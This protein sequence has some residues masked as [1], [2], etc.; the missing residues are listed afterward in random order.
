[1]FERWL[2]RDKI[3]AIQ[4]KDMENVIRE[5]G[6]FEKIISGEILCSECK[7]QINIEGIQCIYMQDDNVNVCCG[8]APCYKSLLGRTGD[9]CIT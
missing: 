6:L 9:Q 4:E 1:M 2:Q 5:L 3:H 7:K 8:D